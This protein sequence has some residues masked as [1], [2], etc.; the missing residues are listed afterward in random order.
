[1]RIAA[2]LAKQVNKAHGRAMKPLLFM[3]T[4]LAL[5]AG[6]P[7][8]AADSAVGLYRLAD[9]HDAAGELLLRDD[10][11]FE[12]ALAYGAL[13]ERA[14]GRWVRNGSELALTTLPKPVAPVF[15]RAPDSAPAPN[16]PTLRVTSPDGRGIGGVDF[17][18]GF[19]SGDPITDYTQEDG[20]SMPPGEHRIPRWIELAEPIYGFMSP[21]YPIAGGTIGNGA[22][23]LNFVII[24][25]DM[26]IVDFTGMV[27]DVLPDEL[28]VHRGAGEMR[29][30]RQPGQR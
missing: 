1:M 20:W 2:P 24:P 7:A 28:H 9:E 26:G 15:R 22:G 4:A 17:R 30:V 8:V 19:D 5:A 11:R 18:I 14:E 3:V 13:D 10:G 27:V 12:Y 6:Q 29:F 21:R 16:A 23:T 25:N